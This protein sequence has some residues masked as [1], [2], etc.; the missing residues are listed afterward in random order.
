MSVILLEVLA[1]GKIICGDSELYKKAQE[2]LHRYVSRRG[3]VRAGRG[4][5]PAALQRGRG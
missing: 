3:L 1:E 5:V 4:W 2:A